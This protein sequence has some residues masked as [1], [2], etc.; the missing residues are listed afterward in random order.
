VRCAAVPRGLGRS[1]LGG[2]ESE[3]QEEE[4]LEKCVLWKLAL[5]MVI[6]SGRGHTVVA[7]LREVVPSSIFHI[8]HRR[9][10]IMVAI[11]ITIRRGG[12]NGS[13]IRIGVLTV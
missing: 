6:R 2:L 13:A 10:N 8:C 1:G 11:A 7:A 9:P 4:K 12:R 3:T 5:R